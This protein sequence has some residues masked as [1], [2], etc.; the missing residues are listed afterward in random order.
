[1]Y[2]TII[3]YSDLSGMLT[4]F[5]C[6]VDV[7]FNN[8]TAAGKVSD[9]SKTGYK[10]IAVSGIYNDASNASFYY[11]FNLNEPNQTL[12]IGVRRYNNQTYTGTFYCSVHILYAKNGF[13]A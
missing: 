9:V 7:T 5:E 2:I 8:V 13:Y 3:Y 11:Q 12:S 1:M 10:A 6:A 4:T